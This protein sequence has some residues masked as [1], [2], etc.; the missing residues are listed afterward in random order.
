MISQ[1]IRNEV[2]LAVKEFNAV[3]K[4]PEHLGD[5]DE[6]RTGMFYTILRRAFK[7]G[8]RRKLMTPKSLEC[9]F[10]PD[11]TIKAFRVLVPFNDYWTLEVEPLR[12]LRELSYE[13]SEF[14]ATPDMNEIAD[15]VNSIK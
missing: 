11:H 5:S 12:Q 10:N 2:Y 15:I 7:F 13:K 6:A 1:N 8:T 3:S 4:R 14:F 9:R